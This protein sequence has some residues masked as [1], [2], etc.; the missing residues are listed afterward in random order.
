MVR[1]GYPDSLLV[2]DAAVGDGVRCPGDPLGG[3]G[4]YDSVVTPVGVWIDADDLA[5]A[6]DGA[7]ATPDDD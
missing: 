5:C 4:T 6:L 2:G 1:G 3:V 7:S